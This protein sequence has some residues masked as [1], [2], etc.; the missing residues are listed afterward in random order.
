M[1]HRLLAVEDRTCNESSVA[2]VLRNWGYTVATASTFDFAAGAGLADDFD[3][4]IINHCDRRINAI[5]IC[6][7]LRWRN[8]QAPVVVL[9]ARDQVPDRI[10]IF[11]AGADVYLPKPVDLDELQVRIEALLVRSVRTRQPEILCYEF[12]GMRVDFRQ[13]ELLRNGLIIELS[14]RLSRLL[15]YFVENRGKTV[16]RSALLQQVWGY[17]ETPL[18]RTVDVHVLRLR[19]KIEDDPKDPRFIV[20]V[21]GFGYRFDG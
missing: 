16:S 19:Q 5:E 3:I 15:R 11:K 7:E 4:I 6:S 13:S 21:H 10:A 8:V 17:R 9:A 18:T 20:T 1:N 2:D 14:Q 12:G